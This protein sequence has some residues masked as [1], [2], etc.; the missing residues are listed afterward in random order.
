VKAKLA[1][2]E[3]LS[4]A[5]TPQFRTIGGVEMSGLVL[6]VICV[7]CGLGFDLSF[8]SWRRMTRAFPDA[9]Y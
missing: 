4:V 3:P 7:I 9:T 1:R 8:A 2:S 5:G 6:C